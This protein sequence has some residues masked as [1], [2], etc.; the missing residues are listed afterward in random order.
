MEY[1]ILN[2]TECRFII[3]GDLNARIGSLNDFVPNDIGRHIDALP[4][5]YMGDTALPR[6][7]SDRS[8]NDNGTLLVDFC[9]QTGLRVANGRVGEDANE[10][11]CTY[12]GSNGSSLI[13]YVIVSEELLGHFSEFYISDPNILSDHCVVNFSLK[14]LAYTNNVEEDLD[15]EHVE[16]KYTFDKDYINEYKT[17]LSSPEITQQLDD[18]IRKLDNIDSHNDIDN[19][20]DCF[21]GTLDSVCEPLFEKKL[22]CNVDNIGNHSRTGPLLN[23]DCE[24]KKLDFLNRLNIYRH[25]KNDINRIEMVRARTEYKRSVRIY[26]FECRKQKSRQLLDLKYKNAKSYWKLLKDSQNTDKSNSLTAQKFSKYFKSINDPDTP[27]YQADEDILEFNNRFLNSEAQVMFS[28]LDETISEQEIVSAIKKLNSGKSGGPDRL[29]NEFFIHGIEILPKYLS[30]LFNVI[31]D[32]GHF[33]SC[34]TD[35]HIVPIHKKGS[36]NTA[37]NYR[38]ITLLSTLGKLFTRIL[39]DRL[40]DWAENYHVYIEAQA[41]FRSNM[42]TVDNIFTL[43]GLLTHVINQGKKL[44]CA[45]VDFTKAFDYINRDI[46]WHKLIKFGVRGKALNIIRS[47]YENVKSRVK[48]KNR[49]S[50]NFECYLGVRQ[51]ESLSPFLF[52]MYLND[53]EDEFYLNGIEGIDIHHIKLFLLLYADDITL[54]S[55][56]AEGL[57]KALNLLSTYCQRWKL[58]V[59]TKKTKIMVFRKGGILPRDLKFYYNG[60][61]IEIVNT[62]S[63]LGIVFSPGGSFSNT[64]ITLAG[65]AQKAIFKLNSYLYK[66]TNISP[67]H[68]IELFDKLVSPI[69]NYAAEVWG[70]FQATHIERVHLQFCK[71]LLGVKKTTQNNFVYGELGR[72]NFQTRRFFIILKYWLKIVNTDENKFIKC[73]YQTML[74]DI[75]IN[76]RKTNW[77][78]LVKKLLSNLGFYEVWLQQ[79][80]GDVNIFLILAKQRLKDNFVQKWNE[81]LNQ[82]S[83]AIFYRS[84][85]NFEFSAYL[86]IITVRKFRFALAKLRTSSHRLEVEMGRWARPERI[87]FENRKCKHCQIL[88]DEYHFILECPLYSNIR[89]LYVKRYFYTRP[90]M[91]KLTE[92]MSSNSKK[93]IRNLATFIFKA[94]EERNR[95]LYINSN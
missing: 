58:T 6:V 83:R 16:T 55:E 41:G 76:D 39:N 7:S 35:G 13:D 40:T 64:Q 63:Y 3:C 80:V 26:R 31:Y 17:K 89:T 67:R 87:A 49:L 94:F 43:H 25:S 52:S 23:E 18:M 50:E 78:L 65:Q 75:D 19:C 72:I 22:P 57:Q 84:I 53:V 73:I 68:T 85:A 20:V 42:G 47:M 37:E 14:N 36:L 88:E 9:I 60:I 51:G 4:E 79:N 92:L 12:V 15:S 46:L 74:T 2:I 61:E 11:K 45:F 38:G 95:I 33:P 86:D 10:G 62:F 21:V 27:F 59:N 90:N 48:Y 81:E 5:D 56:T 29:L 1:A 28:E 30:K 66:F 77:A 24:N 93:Q 70:F 8:V 54:F 34:W 91:F 69:L 32:S 82:S 44:Y 71:R